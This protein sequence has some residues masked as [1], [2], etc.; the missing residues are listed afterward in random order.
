MRC[1]KGKEYRDCNAVPHVISGP[2]DCDARPPHCFGWGP[3]TANIA[4]RVDPR[5][6]ESARVTVVVRYKPSI[7]Q[8]TYNN[9]CSSSSLLLVVIIV[10]ATFDRF[11]VGFF[12]VLVLDFRLGLGSSVL[13]LSGRSPLLL[14][15]ST[16]FVIVLG[17]R[18][19]HAGDNVGAKIENGRAVD[20]TFSAARG[21][22][23]MSAFG[24]TTYEHA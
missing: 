21:A 11:R 22:S 2:A 23:F 9:R 12:I 5:L 6:G 14:W 3:R 20:G 18:I 17:E 1:R 13:L 24:P 7:P 19:G 4:V 15:L 8:N 10:A 16:F